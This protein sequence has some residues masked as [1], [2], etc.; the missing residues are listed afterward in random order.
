MHN[1][2][3]VE[4]GF[5]S[6]AVGTEAVTIAQTVNA[7][8]RWEFNSCEMLVKDGVVYPIDYANACPDVAVT[9]LHYYFPWAMKALLQVVGVLRGDRS[10]GPHPGR[11]RPVVRGRRRPGAGLPG[12]ARGLPRARGRPLRDRPLPR[13]LRRRPCRTS[14]RWCSSG[15]TPTTSAALL[16]DTIQP[17]YPKHEWDKFE[18][19]FG[20]LTR[21]WVIDE[22]VAAQPGTVGRRRDRGRR[23]GAGPDRLTQATPDDDTGPAVVAE[24]VRSTGTGASAGPTLLLDLVAACLAAAGAGDGA[25]RGRGRG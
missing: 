22:T 20:G 18:G 23:A 9:S 21:L 17:T 6:E 16:T 19:H 24:P 5:L 7:F 4:H 15:S 8:F 1:R 2:Y 12:Q 13:V 14:T 11:H 10:Q 25:G 3:A